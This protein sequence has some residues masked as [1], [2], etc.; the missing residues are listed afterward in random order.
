MMHQRMSHQD[1]S[2][3]VTITKYITI[4]YFN[5]EITAK[6]QEHNRSPTY[7]TYTTFGLQGDR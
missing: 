3:S 6:Y 1:S 5:L 7:S 2:E 4:T